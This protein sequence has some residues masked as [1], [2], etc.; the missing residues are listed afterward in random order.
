MAWECIEAG[1]ALKRQ[2]ELENLFCAV[3]T[4]EMK[5]PHGKWLIGMLSPG[6]YIGEIAYLLAE[7]SWHRTVVAANAGSQILRIDADALEAAP[8]ARHHKF[9]RAFLARLVQHPRVAY[10]QFTST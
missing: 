8:T 4:D 3:A 1:T 2:N 10:T 7:S 6:E 5:V 9:D